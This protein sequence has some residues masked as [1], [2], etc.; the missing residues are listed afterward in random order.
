MN[1][2]VTEY[3]IEKNT[4][5][6]TFVHTNLPFIIY[7]DNRVDI[8]I[9]VEVLEE[10]NRLKTLFNDYYSYSKKDKIVIKKIRERYINFSHSIGNIFHTE[11][12]LLEINKGIKDK[13]TKTM[14]DAGIKLLEKISEVLKGFCTLSYKAKGV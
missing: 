14:L 5:S 2:K 8:K 11:K 6:G 12:D 7:L 13:K 9:M 10:L 1:V 4:I 3:D